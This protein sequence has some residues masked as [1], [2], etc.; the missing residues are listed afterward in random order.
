MLRVII[1]PGYGMA[2]AQAQ[3]QK[4][5]ADKLEAR[6]RRLI[7]TH[8]VAGRM[9]GHMNVLLAEADVPYEKLKVMEEIDHEFEECDLQ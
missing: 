9:P 5:L 1:V 6:V 3:Q 7:C 4:Q 8:P 2:L